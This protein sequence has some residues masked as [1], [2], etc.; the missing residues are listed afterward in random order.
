MTHR[1][2]IH[3]ATDRWQHNWLIDKT[4]RWRKVLLV[5]SNLEAALDTGR[6]A[7]I[8]RPGE[9]RQGSKPEVLNLR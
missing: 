9:A 1:L 4:Y 8:Q 6:Q 3:I 2:V 7:G 5:G